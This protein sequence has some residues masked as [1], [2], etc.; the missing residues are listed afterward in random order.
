MLKKTLISLLTLLA[1]TTGLSSAQVVINVGAK[2]GINFADIRT[3]AASGPGFRQGF[4]GGG[5]VTVD[6]VGPLAFQSEALYMGKGFRGELIGRPEN[7]TL[8]LSYLE[9]PLLLKIQA[10]MVGNSR[11]NVYAG[12]ALSYKLNESFDVPP[13][14]EGV[15][16]PSED[17]ARSFD[18]GG[19][20][21][22]E[23]GFELGGGLL[24]LDIRF[25]PGLSDI[26]VDGNNSD[27]ALDPDASNQV[28][29]LMTGFVF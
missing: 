26:A 4:A 12:P 9:I 7:A 5:F 20:V 6:L 23:F 1:C 3:Q 22:I 29:T 28:F 14:A 19:S 17:V 21:G 13:S 10:P 15:D 27:Y 2:A 24:L 16:E 11:S 18:I 8:S 25:T